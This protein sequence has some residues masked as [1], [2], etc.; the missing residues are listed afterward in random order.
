MTNEQKNAVLEFLNFQKKWKKY[1][2]AFGK[3]L[4]L[5][6]GDDFNRKVRLFTGL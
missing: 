1:L 3:D 4:D 6:F 2:K 5:L